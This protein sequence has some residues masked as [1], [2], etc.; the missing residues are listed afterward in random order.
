MEKVKFNP[1]WVLNICLTVS[2]VF[3]LL[4]DFW[5]KEIPEIIFGG[6]KLGALMY[7]ISLAFITSYTFFFVNDLMKKK[8]DKA[9]LSPYLA[10]KT[11]FIIQRVKITHQSDPPITV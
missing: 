5:L 2:L 11:Y 9:N 6:Q 7:Q 8:V 1:N 4:Y 3:I 10:K